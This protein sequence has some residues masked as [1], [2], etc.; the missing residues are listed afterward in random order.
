MQAISFHNR[1]A[2]FLWGFAVIWLAMLLAMTWVTVR[3]GPPEG[4]SVHAMLVIGALFWMAGLALLGFIAGQPCSR[5]SLEPGGSVQLTWRY[6]F[7]VKRRTLSVH[8]LVPAEVVEI[9]D[10]EG[11]PYFLL[12][13][14]SLDGERMD[15]FE[16]SDRKSAE[17]CR[18]Q[19][20]EALGKYASQ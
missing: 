14:Q 15:I 6:P 9:R 11:D 1:K 13:V 17:D 16:S 3:D 12:R 10:S 18:E 5:L 7:H 2:G 4:Y 8:Q 19:F 20:N